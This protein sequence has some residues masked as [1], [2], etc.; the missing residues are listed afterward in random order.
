MEEDPKAASMLDDAHTA[1]N[2]RGLISLG[3]GVGVGLLTVNAPD[4]QGPI[5]KLFF[6]GDLA[7]IAPP[8]AAGLCHWA[9]AGRTVRAESGV[10]SPT[11]RP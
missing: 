10:E 4:L 3:V 8:I 1:F 6:D 5:S 2:T 7:W 11:A 9:I